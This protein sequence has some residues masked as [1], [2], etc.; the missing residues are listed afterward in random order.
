MLH[1]SY[2]IVSHSARMPS[3][4][5]AK[6]NKPQEA[7]RRKVAPRKSFDRICDQNR[8]RVLGQSLGRDKERKGLTRDTSCLG[9]LTPAR[10]VRYD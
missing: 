2:Q 4:S 3:R 7:V 1:D 9:L 5:E 8:D 6:Q 10:C